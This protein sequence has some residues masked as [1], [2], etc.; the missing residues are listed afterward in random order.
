MEDKKEISAYIL[1]DIN[2]KWNYVKKLGYKPIYMGLKGS[3]NYELDVYKP[4]YQSDIDVVCLVIP[5]TENFLLGKSEISTTL[6]CEDNSHIELK[7][8]Q[9][10]I[11]MLEKANISF[12]E[13]LFTNY[14]FIDGEVDNGFM[15]YLRKNAEDF[16]LKNLDKLFH[17]TKGHFY[18]KKSNLYSAKGNQEEE[19]SEY[20]YA[21]K[22]IHHMY[23]IINFIDQYYFKRMSFKDSLIPD[24]D[25]KIEL[26]KLKT[27]KV[28]IEVIRDLELRLEQKLKDYEELLTKEYLEGMV[29]FN[30][31]NNN[32]F[33]ITKSKM[34]EMLKEN[35]RKELVHEY[36]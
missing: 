1:N 35:I 4:K 7:D 5:S 32:L 18:E 27:S 13:I 30:A 6:V 19:I 34:L 28:N 2:E 21:S 24:N 23:R 26:N 29:E 25:S 12:L 22:Q 9:S 17:C 15:T 11:R 8:I 36:L 20:G 31:F 33:E 3:Q 10:Y 16:V 14:F